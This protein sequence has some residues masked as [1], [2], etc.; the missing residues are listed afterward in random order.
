MKSRLGEQ[1]PMMLF[2]AAAD[3]KEQLNQAAGYDQLM[4]EFIK[5]LY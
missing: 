5:K 4:N 2:D 1:K 3:D